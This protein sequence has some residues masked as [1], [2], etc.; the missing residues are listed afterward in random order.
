[1][2]QYLKDGI[3]SNKVELVAHQAQVAHHKENMPQVHD[4]RKEG[5]FIVYRDGKVIIS[6]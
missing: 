4:T 2:E 6:E 3:S 5:K 1:M